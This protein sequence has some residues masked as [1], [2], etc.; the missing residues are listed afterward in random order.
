MFNEAMTRWSSVHMCLSAM[1]ALH[2]HNIKG[3]KVSMSSC[4][5]ARQLIDP[6]LQLHRRKCLHSLML[7]I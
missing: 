6:K 4:E 3:A 5:L 1:I 2:W 7:P